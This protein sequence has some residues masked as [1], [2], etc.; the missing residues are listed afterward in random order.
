MIGFY[1]FSELLETLWVTMSPAVKSRS[2]SHRMWIFIC[3]CKEMSFVRFDLNKSLSYIKR[4][5]EKLKWWVRNILC[6]PSVEYEYTEV[7]SFWSI[8]GCNL[9]R[10]GNRVSSR[11]VVGAAHK[12]FNRLYARTL[13]GSGTA[14]DEMV[15]RRSE[16]IFKE[17][18]KEK[19]KKCNFRPNY[20]KLY[21][22][23]HDGSVMVHSGVTMLLAKCH[24]PFRCDHVIS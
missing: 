17:A 8:G 9:R 7:P 11:R 22:M 5:C 20:C 1:L 21:A 14:L 15:E 24:G 6:L 19:K 18:S 12:R 13:R 3:L 16:R 10:W 4:T 23:T 2:F